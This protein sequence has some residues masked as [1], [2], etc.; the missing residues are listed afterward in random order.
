[1]TVELQ[2]ELNI[3][4]LHPPVKTGLGMTHPVLM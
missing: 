1:M 2:V 3:I 4:I